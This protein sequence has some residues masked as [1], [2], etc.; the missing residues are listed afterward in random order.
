MAT[1]YLQFEA[2]ADA[3]ADRIAENI[4]EN[5][6][7]L[8]EVEEADAETETTRFG[9]GV[10]ETVVLISGVVTIAKQG[11]EL[12]GA[13]RT[14]VQSLTGLVQDAQGLRDAFIEI[15]RRRVRVSELTE[16][17]MAELAAEGE[18]STQP[19]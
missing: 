12:I 13:L 6:N 16:A 1:I 7:N 14:L 11:S 18:A 17:D 3:E 19:A 4:R 15:G 9:I 2:A 5:L 10:V 8:E